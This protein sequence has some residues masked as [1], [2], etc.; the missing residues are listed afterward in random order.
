MI[1]FETKVKF[2][3]MWKKYVL[4]AFKSER[5]EY[6]IGYVRLN[7]DET[8]LSWTPTEENIE[9]VETALL[10]I[11]YQP[12]YFSFADKGQVTS[13]RQ[14]YVDTDGYWRQ[15]HIRVHEDG[16]IR[17]HD[18]LSYEDSAIDHVKGVGAQEIYDSAKT[19][20]LAILRNL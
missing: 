16:E 10:G 20:V 6:H 3:Q 2:W 13:M 4:N 8:D 11:D 12:N 5:E 1:L 18:E 19:N 7:P 9:K 14:M 17:G 15:I